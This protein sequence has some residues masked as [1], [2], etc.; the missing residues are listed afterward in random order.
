MSKEAIEKIREAE[1]KAA[2][3]RAEAEQEARRRVE[4][5]E[6]DGAAEAARI[7]DAASAEWKQRL[8][9]VRRKTDTLVE[10]SR[11]A[12][13]ADIDEMEAE[14]KKH[15]HEATK[16]IVWEMFDACQ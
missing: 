6:K 5:A 4:Q 9:D 8:E 13:S 11:E 2:A 3:I 14:A 15:I 12:A 1:I 7:A 16:L 10:Q